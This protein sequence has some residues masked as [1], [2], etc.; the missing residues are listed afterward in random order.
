MVRACFWGFPTAN[1]QLAHRIRLTVRNWSP[2]LSFH[3]K[4]G[5]EEVN[6]HSDVSPLEE[7]ITSKILLKWDFSIEKLAGEARG[8]PD[9]YICQ[10]P[11]FLDKDSNHNKFLIRKFLMNKYQLKCCNSEPKPREPHRLEYPRRSKRRIW[12][13]LLPNLNPL[14]WP[15]LLKNWWKCFL[16][17]R[18]CELLDLA[19]NCANKTVLEASN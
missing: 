6:Q 13:L 4:T 7:D 2:I 8:L 12:S 10:L 5:V 19:W 15:N 11:A 3:K 17:L 1:V 9:A 18:P 14:F 16:F